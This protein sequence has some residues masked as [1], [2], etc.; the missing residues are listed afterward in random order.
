MVSIA[1]PTSFLATSGTLRK[2]IFLLLEV[3]DPFFSH[4][5]MRVQRWRDG[6]TMGAGLEIRPECFLLGD[7]CINSTLTL[8]ETGLGACLDP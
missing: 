8:W 2:V 4:S 3:P 5:G 7:K 1:Y 6:E